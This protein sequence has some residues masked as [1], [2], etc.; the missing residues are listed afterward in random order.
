MAHE[1]LNKVQLRGKVGQIT[2]HRYAA[3]SYYSFSVVTETYAKAAD[4][5]PI[6]DTTWLYVLS[7]GEF[8]KG[9]IPSKGDW[10]EVNGRIKLSRYTGENGNDMTQAS[11]VAREVIVLDKN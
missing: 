11:I 1:Y 6:I 10:V 2:E 7:W 8:F 5:T 4:G 3:G 9:G